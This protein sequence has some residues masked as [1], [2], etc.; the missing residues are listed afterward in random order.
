MS[1]DFLS[2]LFLQTVESVPQN[3]KIVLA[4]R[5]VLTQ[6]VDILVDGI[7]LNS[8]EAEFLNKFP[9]EIL[10]VASRSSN[11][12]CLGLGSFEVLCEYILAY[13]KLVKV[14]LSIFEVEVV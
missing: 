14:S 2:A 9:S 6:K 1:L 13:S 11:L 8:R 3:F 5:K 4:D 7:A 12:Q 10:N